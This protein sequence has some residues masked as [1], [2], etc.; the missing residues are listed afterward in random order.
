[1]AYSVTPMP[2]PTKNLYLKGRFWTTSRQSAAPAICSHA[3][4]S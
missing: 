3:M 4:V 1:M 2:S